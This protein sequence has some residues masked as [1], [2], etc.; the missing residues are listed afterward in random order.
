MISIAFNVANVPNYKAINRKN[1]AM[2]NAK[3]SLETQ[4]KAITMKNE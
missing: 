2:S 1:V 3:L 4:M